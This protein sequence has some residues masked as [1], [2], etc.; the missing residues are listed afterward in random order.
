MCLL[1]GMLVLLFILLGIAAFIKKEWLLLDIIA[2]IIYIGSIIV[3]NEE[4]F[5]YDAI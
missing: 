1:E 3:V 5:T 2:I 4:T